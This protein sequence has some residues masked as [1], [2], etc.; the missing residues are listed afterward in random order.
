MSKIL[1]SMLAL[2][3]AFLLGIATPAYAAD[4][5]EGMEPIKIEI[6]ELSFGMNGPFDY[7]SPNL[8]QPSFKDRVP[9][10]VPK[11][12]TVVSRGKPVTSSVKAPLRGNLQMLV[13]GDKS[14][15]DASL[16]E[17]EGGPQW[18]Q[19]DLGAEYE[20]YAVLLWHFHKSKR[21]YFDVIVQASD[22][23]EFKI[24]ATLYNNDRENH[25][26]HGA[27]KDKEYLDTNN[28]RLIDAKGVRARY[29]RCHSNGNS[30]DDKNDYIEIEVF[31]RPVKTAASAA[32]ASAKPASSVSPVSASSP[33]QNAN[34]TEGKEPIKIELPEPF[35][36]G[37]PLDGCC[38]NLEP[39]DFLNR[40][41]FMAPKGTAVVSRDKPVT[42]SVKTPLQGDLKMIVDGDNSFDK[43]SIVELESGVQWVQVDLEA[44]Y[45]VYA[46]LLWHFRRGLCVY[47]D[48]IV[49]VSNDPEFKSGV[50]TLRNADRENRAGLGAGKDLD[51]V[52]YYSGRLIDAKGTRAR[53]I[54]CYSN[55]N[56]SDDKNHYVEVEVFGRPVK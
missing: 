3:G 8:E 36:G 18:V 29:L 42:S 30:V 35:F 54:R 15:D 25:I 22:S 40:P 13:D 5:A 1:L 26:G 16:V 48:V 45:D 17:L 24:W 23:P 27:G 7:D 4:A 51:Y 53:Y 11:G 32:S 38:P 55:G 31:G 46:I 37:T 6:P 14:Y 34:G 47:F 10:Q 56:T 28:G 49:Q 33:A 21:V 52:E 9:F 12:T 20:I 44:E 2:G 43:N 39:L 50:S 41:P 19:V